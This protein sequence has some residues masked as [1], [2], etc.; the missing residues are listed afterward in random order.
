MVLF[1]FSFF[2]KLCCHPQGKVGECRQKSREGDLG[3]GSAEP[4]TFPYSELL[5]NS[6][7]PVSMLAC[8]WW[9]SVDLS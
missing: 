7:G 5:H 2:P 4:M 3:E 1:P 8:V 6:P 9:L